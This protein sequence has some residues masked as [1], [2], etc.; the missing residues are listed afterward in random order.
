MVAIYDFVG[1]HW[2]FNETSDLYF[3][4]FSAPH[5]VPRMLFVPTND[6]LLI[7]FIKIHLRIFSAEEKSIVVNLLNLEDYIPSV[8][9]ARRGISGT[10]KYSLFDKMFRSDAMSFCGT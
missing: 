3:A 6:F 7:D 9:S 1:K 5:I 8:S 4:V 2:N 10:V